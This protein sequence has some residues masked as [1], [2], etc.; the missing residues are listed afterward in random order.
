MIAVTLMS[1]VYLKLLNHSKINSA[2]AVKFV[3]FLTSDAIDFVQKIEVKG[4]E[5]EST[6]KYQTY[7]EEKM[8][9][10]VYFWT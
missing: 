1:E 2:L 7:P 5:E 6:R 4:R 9:V 3:M 8:A 10:R